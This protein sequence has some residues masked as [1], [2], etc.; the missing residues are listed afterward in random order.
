MGLFS[1]PSVSVRIEQNRIVFQQSRYKRTMKEIQLMH[2]CGQSK[3]VRRLISIGVHENELHIHSIPAISYPRIKKARF[4]RGED[5]GPNFFFFL[6]LVIF[7]ANNESAYNEI[8]ALTK[9][10][11]GPFSTILPHLT[12]ASYLCIRNSPIFH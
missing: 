3:K 1:F 8:L 5:A 7:S 2:Y 9:Q 12:N 4:Y 11:I 10:Q 6:F